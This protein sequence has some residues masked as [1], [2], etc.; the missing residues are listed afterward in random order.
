MRP[1]TIRV[2][3]A[4]HPHFIRRPSGRQT[5]LL[6]RAAPLVYI[7]TLPLVGWEKLEAVMK[8]KYP[9]ALALHCMV[10]IETEESVTVFDFLPELPTSPVVA[11][12]L[13]CGGHVKGVVRERKLSQLPFKR[14][15]LVGSS[16]QQQVNLA[17]LSSS[18]LLQSQVTS[19]LFLTA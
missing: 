18:Y 6:C 7:A 12:A 17:L 14:C 15:W 2:T 8:D 11:A 9:D 10:L 1:S 5:C 16:A 19:T 3:R 13:L 4:H